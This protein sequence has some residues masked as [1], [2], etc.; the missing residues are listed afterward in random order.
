MNENLRQYLKDSSIAMEKHGIEAD[1]RSNIEGLLKGYIETEDDASYR[2]MVKKWHKYTQSEKPDDREWGSF[3]LKI[4][5]EMSPGPK[6][7]EI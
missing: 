2:R 4:A 6:W 1:K 3:C 5:R 7:I